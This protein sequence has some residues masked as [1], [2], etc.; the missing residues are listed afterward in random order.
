MTVDTTYT[1]DE[2]K[3]NG[4]RHVYPVSKLDSSNAIQ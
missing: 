3:I 2:V 1:P 4:R